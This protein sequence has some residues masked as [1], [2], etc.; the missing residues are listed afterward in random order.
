MADALKEPAWK[1]LMASRHSPPMA[2]V[3]ALGAIDYGN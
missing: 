2:T 3:I 1:G